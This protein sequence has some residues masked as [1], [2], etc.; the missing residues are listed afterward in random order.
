MREY[1]ADGENKP[2]VSKIIEKKDTLCRVLS[3]SSNC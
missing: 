3:F 2:S 1:D